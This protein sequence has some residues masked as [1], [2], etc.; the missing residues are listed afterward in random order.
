MKTLLIAGGSASGKSWLTRRV[1]DALGKATLISQDA[2]YHDRPSGSAE[3]RHNFDFDQPYAIDWDEMA[4]ALAT[5]QSGQ[6]AQIPIYDFSVS[7]RDGY[8]DLTPEGDILIID[9]TL[10][11]SQPKIREIADA[12]L[13]VRCPEPLR[14]ARRERRDVEER[15][16]HID[17]VRQQLAE[18]VFPAH[19]THV[20]PSAAHAD[21]VLEAPDIVADPDH[22]VSQ[23]LELLDKS[24]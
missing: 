10:V 12:A 19:N 3:D 9:G 17:F 6:T 7:L 18:Q 5:L 15:G 8:E 2:F 4:R 13:Y 11:L 1:K 24:S 22:A 21:L 14:R 20:L 16:R 23:V